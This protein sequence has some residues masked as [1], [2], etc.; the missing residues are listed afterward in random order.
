MKRNQLEAKKKVHEILKL[1][2]EIDQDAGQGGR[3]KIENAKIKQNRARDRRF[4]NMKE[5][6]KDRKR[7]SKSSKIGLIRAHREVST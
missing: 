6:L 3:A 1:N 2:R 5:K 7:N 4:K